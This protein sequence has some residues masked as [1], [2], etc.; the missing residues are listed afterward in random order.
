MV[1]HSYLNPA[2][3]HLK[4]SGLNRIGYWEK[5]EETAFRFWLLTDQM[6]LGW[7]EFIATSTTTTFLFSRPICLLVLLSL[8]VEYRRWRWP[9]FFPIPCFFLQHYASSPSLLLT[10]LSETQASD[11]RNHT[12]RTLQDT[13]GLWSPSTLLVFPFLLLRPP[14]NPF[15]VLSG[16]DLYSIN[17][18]MVCVWKS[19]LVWKWVLHCM[20]KDKLRDLLVGLVGWLY[21]VIAHLSF[22]SLQLS[23]FLFSCVHVYVYVCVYVPIVSGSRSSS[24]GV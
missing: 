16:F 10:H 15:C 5:K 14:W 3:N 18:S 22:S 4:N 24:N 21:G 7:V 23:L 20:V 17:R 19:V 9:C 8:S 6:R 11:K 2:R 13:M 1:R 12:V